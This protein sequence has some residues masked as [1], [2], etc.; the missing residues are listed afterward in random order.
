M[1]TMRILLCMRLSAITGLVMPICFSAESD[2]LQ[3][4]STQVYARHFELD[5]MSVSA[6]VTLIDAE[7]IRAAEASSVPEL[8][9]KQANLLFRSNNGKMADSEVALRG[10]GE[11]S[12]QRV[13]IVVDGQKFNRPDL[14]NIEWQ[15]IPLQNIE[16]IEVI[17]GAQN[18]LYGNHA[19][20]GVIKITTKKGGEDLHLLKGRAGSF[21]AWHGSVYSSGERAGWYYAAGY[22][23][24]EDGGY[25]EHAFSRAQIGHVALGYQ[26]SEGSSITLRSVYSDSLLQIPGPI[27]L[28][29][30][31]TNPTVS[32][33]DGQQVTMNRTSL[34]TVFW[35]SDQAWGATQVNC[36][37]LSRDL[38]WSLGG[39]YADNRQQGFSLTPRLKWGA[40]D[41]ALYCGVDCLLD[42]VSYDDFSDAAKTDAR[43]RA[44]IYRWQVGPYLFA[45]KALTDKISLNGGVR[46]EG[47]YTDNL[48]ANN[49]DPAAS[50]D[51]S[52][53]KRGWAVECAVNCKLNDYCSLWLS[54]DRLYRYP[55]L[56][57]VAAYQGFALQQPLNFNLDP[58]QGNS[59]ELGVKWRQRN[60]AFSAA[61]YHT[62][63]QDE[64]VYDA[65]DNL[66]INADTTRRLGGDIELS[67]TQT[68]WGVS[69]RWSIVDAEFADG[70][71][72]GRTI[73]LVPAYHGVATVWMRPFEPLR[74]SV[75]GNYVAERY[76]GN[77]DANTFRP[78]SAYILGHLMV[79][80][81][82]H[83][84][85]SASFKI[86]NLFDRHYV[87]SAY[88][89]AYYPGSGRSY[90]FGCSLTF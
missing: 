18:V 73:P 19:L 9:S 29:Q 27:T 83:S 40:G 11:N 42:A 90:E 34:T 81:K 86:N 58:E 77:D 44:E 63:L 62:T 36:G 76:Q 7:M 55:A 14:G 13:L 10:F 70:V 38:D 89:G 28:S 8:L 16:S 47:V 23:Y 67:Y 78:I 49:D 24:T 35:E 53:D 79:T 85:L 88:Q 26:L 87:S 68:S 39:V 30:F 82:L 31:E 22:D 2:V 5:E 72:A 43:G 56:D 32:N 25:R 61:L 17:R 21:D 6:D 3:L 65:I 37:W 74:I 64:I 52:I 15:Q 51:G 50:F 75:Y 54:Y 12:G 69:S 84:S 1:V 66:N 41:N 57:E 59:F 46:Y 33:N 60:L 45:E 20:S 4:P 48:Y 80:C 71:H